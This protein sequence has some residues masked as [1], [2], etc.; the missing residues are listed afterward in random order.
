MTKQFALVTVRTSSTRLPRKCLEVIAGELTSIQ[1]VIRRA[2]KIGCPVIL[3]TTEDPSDD[4]LVEI[5]H[6][7]DVEC[8]RGSVKNKIRRWADCFE[9]YEISEGLLVDGDDPTFDYNAG[10]RALR[11]LQKADVDLVV[12]APEMTPGFFTYGITGAAMKR[13]L[14]QAPDPSRDTDV[15]TEF[16]KRAQ[17]KQ[18]YLEP[19]PDEITEHQI[20]LT[21]DY[22]EDL[23]FY[24]ELYSRI[25]CL[26]PAAKIV[27][28]ALGA[29][30]QNINWKMQDFFLRNQKQFNESVRLADK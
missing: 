29:E 10:A 1:V 11:C 26:A 3:A 28:T 14:L 13:L 6:K 12:P 20:R 7:E 25:D 18:E 22:P 5:A 2:K 27:Q 23:V 8:F 9:Q 24:R 4:I 21:I 30:L 16:V 15:I 17:L 19:L